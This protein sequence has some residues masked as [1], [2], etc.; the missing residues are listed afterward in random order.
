MNTSRPRGSGLTRARSLVEITETLDATE[1]ETAHQLMRL[2]VA[3]N[4]H[5]GGTWNH[6]APGE[7]TR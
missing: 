3:E 5:S 4:S 2:G 1:F 6:Y 7:H